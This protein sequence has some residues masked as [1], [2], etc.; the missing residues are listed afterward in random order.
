MK[1]IDLEAI[2]K[3]FVKNGYKRY[4]GE[5]CC[6]SP[7]DCDN[8]LEEFKKHCYHDG[9]IEDILRKELRKARLEK[10]LND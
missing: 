4:N 10:L 6:I 5:G 7:W 1:N 8:C 2:W 3:R 9:M